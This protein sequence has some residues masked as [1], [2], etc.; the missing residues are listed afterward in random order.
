MPEDQTL[1][2]QLSKKDIKQVT[3]YYWCSATFCQPCIRSP[4]ATK[5]NTKRRIE[6]S[7]VYQTIVSRRSYGDEDSPIEEQKS[8]NQILGDTFR[9][10]GAAREKEKISNIV[11]Q[12]SNNPAKG[13]NKPNTSSP[14]AI[15]GNNE[16][17]VAN[18]QKE[19]S[20][21]EKVNKQLFS[22]KHSMSKSRIHQ[23]KDSLDFD[24]F[25]KTIHKS[26]NNF[27]IQGLKGTSK[28]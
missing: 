7:G 6:N 22:Y 16:D 10:T 14:L 20:A 28:G 8:S 21:F 9:Q 17:T 18:D 3:W 25:S 5:P 19:C 15:T 13:R 2:I 27:G 24:H 12:F 11:Q 23:S 1:D 26:Q 4:V